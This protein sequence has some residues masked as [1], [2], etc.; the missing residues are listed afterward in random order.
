GPRRRGDG[1]R[2]SAPVA[3]HPGRV[4][5]GLRSRG[6][7]PRPPPAG[8]RARALEALHA[9]RALP[10]DPAGAEERELSPRRARAA[11]RQA[12]SFVARSGA[13]LGSTSSSE[14]KTTPLTSSSSTR[15]F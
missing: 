13:P 15:T 7:P 9:A 12:A 11:L 2:D 14:A 6:R 8:R 4:S 5:L 10:G 1:P 3:T